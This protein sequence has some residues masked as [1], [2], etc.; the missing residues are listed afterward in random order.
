MVMH[1]LIRLS[2]SA[3]PIAMLVAPWTA[4]AQTAEQS[5][6]AA[7]TSEPSLG[8]IIVTAQKRAENLQKAPVA[9]TALSASTLEQRSLDQPVKLQYAVPSLTF[10][11]NQGF[12]TITLRGVGTDLTALG[13]STVATYQDGVY[14]GQIISQSVPTFDLERVEVL[15]GPQ[16]TLY[17]RNTTGG[18]IN[19]IT[20]L[21][22]FEPGAYG[23]VSYGNYD[24]VQADFGITG[25][26]VEDKIALRGNFHYGD[27]DG[28]YFNQ[29]TG[30]RVY[31]ERALGGRLTALIKPTETLQLTLRGDI[32]NYR[33][34]AA[35]GILSI[36]YSDP[37]SDDAHPLGIFSQPASFFTANPGFLS[38]TDIAKLGG[39]S[40]ADYYGLTQP[41]P[42][43]PNLLKTRVFSNSSPTLF[44]TKAKGASATFDWELGDI[45]VKSISAYRK[46]DFYSDQD[47][48]GQSFPQVV[49][50]PL[51]QTNS[52]FTQEFNLSGKSFGGNLEWLLGGFH[53][54]EKG[55]LNGTFF[56]PAF[57]DTVRAGIYL[58]NPAGSPFA[59]NLNRATLPTLNDY[60]G[61]PPSPFQTVTINGPDLDGTPLTA[62]QSV[63]KSAFIG[64]VAD[65]VSKS[66][67][68][69]FQ[70]TYHVTDKLRVTGGFR[71]T[72]D[73]KNTNR[74]LQSN[75]LYN[76]T[77]I[78][79]IGAN[80]ANGAPP[81]TAAAVEAASGVCD[82]NTFRKWSGATG[83]VGLDY[84][85]AP[86]ILTYAKAA[87][88]YKSGGIN[89]GQ[90]KGSYEPEHL[91]DYEG[92]IKALWAGGQIL[93]NLA[94]YY[95]DYSDIQFT[96]YFGNGSQVL[97]AGSATAFGVE[98]EYAFRPRILPGWSL[99]GSV[100]Y[101]DSQ[102][103]EGCFGD[104][105]NFNNAGFLSTPLQACPAAVN[106]AT[107]LG[108]AAGTPGSLPIGPSASIKGN[109]LIRAPRWKMNVGLQ[110]DASLGDAGKLSTRVDA[111]WTDSYHNDILNAREPVYALTKQPAYWMLNA[112]IGWTTSDD[113]FSFL[114]FGDNLL[115]TTHA[116]YRV[117]AHSTPTTYQVPAQLAAPRTYGIRLTAKL[118]SAAR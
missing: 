56:L 17:G 4:H 97:N 78:A 110:Y 5:A 16:G 51:V 20:K 21:P 81:P 14:T 63:P 88:G 54:H 57:G 42:I 11:E 40:I 58:A 99:D 15:R 44:K 106:P 76:L 85:L 77:A 108:V 83:T 71:Y 61:I 52:Q 91:T 23:A 100:S 46:S 114:V 26:L 73:S 103:G 93:T 117:A 19:Y 79:L 118:G 101:Q 43:P 75:F 87:W 47:S 33:T 94:M 45:N 27:H 65:Q 102:Y 68:G 36:A 38:P 18:V 6:A 92:G 116:T 104:P 112:R 12:S 3:A 13:E 55:N 60:P 53:L 109:Q 29:A 31:A 39:G 30:K 2:L 62:F 59:F 115:D 64:F 72:W 32:S 28:Y 25:G 37:L 35:V 69:F 10:G 105:G 50:R 66:T 49:I 86:H 34:S 113:R 24:A 8:E 7:Q 70:A 80:S 48:G 9:I 1:K 82:V 107:G 67:A 95:Y 84:D 111:A 90:C 98:F 74:I 89:P 22:D 96:T 41:G